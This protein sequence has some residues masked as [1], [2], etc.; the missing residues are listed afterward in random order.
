MGW[1]WQSFFM[2]QPWKSYDSSKSV[3]IGSKCREHV[4][5]CKPLTVTAFLI[6]FKV[7]IEE[8]LPIESR[9]SFGSCASM[10]LSLQLACVD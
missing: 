2:D 10:K 1:Y 4:E 9:L 5:G 3:S 8:I 7:L 6:S